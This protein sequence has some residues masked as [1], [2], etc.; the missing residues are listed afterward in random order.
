MADALFPEEAWVEVLKK[1]DDYDPA[2]LAGENVNVTTD[3]S[4][5]EESGFEREVEYK[6]FF[7]NSKVTIKKS[8]KEGQIKFNAKITRALWDQ[9]L[10]GRSGSDFV[11]GGNQEDYRITFL[12]TKESTVTLAS[13]AL[14]SG[15]DH[16]RKIYAD[17]NLISFNPKLEVDGMLEGEVTFS[18]PA[19]DSDGN[20]N[21]RSQI[22][23]AAFAAVGSYTDSQKWD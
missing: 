15:N 11:S 8:Q 10:H 20:G 1:G 9:I 12:V 4:S 17:C 3:I 7:H 23:N 19:T 6:T 22:G 16:Y 2:G 21:I 5:F 14:S 18:L 13:G